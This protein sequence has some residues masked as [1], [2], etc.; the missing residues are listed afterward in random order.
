MRCIYIKEE[1]EKYEVRL[2]YVQAVEELVGDE[3]KK[4]YAVNKKKKRKKLSDFH[5][6]IEISTKVFPTSSDIYNK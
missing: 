6:I 2:R 4:W 1:D 3:S 5:K